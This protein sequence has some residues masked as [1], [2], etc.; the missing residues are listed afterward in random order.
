MKQDGSAWTGTVTAGV[1][2]TPEYPYKVKP[3]IFGSYVTG[4]SS[5]TADAA[6]GTA[7][8]TDFEFRQQPSGTYLF[9][10]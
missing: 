6:T 10:A 9:R 1:Q 2:F 8:F 3:S 7:T 4:I 5:T